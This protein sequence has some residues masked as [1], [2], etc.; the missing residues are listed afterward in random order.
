VLRFSLRLRVLLLIIAINVAVV[1]AETWVLARQL[2]QETRRETEALAEDLVF[3]LRD[4]LQPEAV[5]MEAALTEELAPLLTAW[6]PGSSTDVARAAAR[7]LAARAVARLLPRAGFNAAP[8]LS[9]PSWERFSDAILLDGNIRRTASGAIV[10]LGVALNPIGRGRRSGALD[11]QKVYEAI[12]RSIRS[13][14]PVDQIEGGRVVPI[15]GAEG[16]FGACWYQLPAQRRRDL[17]LR[18]V[19][20]AFAFSTILLSAGTFFALRRFVLDPVARLAAGAS[21]IA[22]G[23]LSV[24]VP[25]KGSADEVSRLIATFNRMTARVSGFN[26]E[27]AHE[28]ERAT[29]AARQ[30]E[31]AAMT[32]RRLAAMGE[33]AAG[34]AHEINN[35]LGGLMNAAEVLGR[36]D[37][38]VERRRRYVELL[39]GGLERIGRTVGQLLR[40]TPRSAQA[41]SLSIVQP[42]LDAVALVRHRAQA[43][44]VQLSVSDGALASTEAD[45]PA[46][47]AASLDALPRVRGEAHEIA[48]AVLNLLVNALDALEERPG[49]ARGGRVEVQLTPT[50]TGLRLEVADDGPGVAREVLERASDLF[51]TTKAPGKGTGLGLSIVHSV[52]AAHGGSVHIDSA[53]GAGFRVRIELPADGGTP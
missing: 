10:P 49:E 18:Y 19:L 1:G 52:V 33:L 53:P 37:I 38:P 9:W 27:L 32:Q 26:E 25:E 36:E 14:Q 11:E 12:A 31:A 29:A 35:P 7:D 21:A 41:V 46:P 8:L 34:I 44:G 15:R 2:G 4:K 6:L 30:A 39:A 45:L 16:V 24:R 20:P 3:T 40:F 51:F 23:D 48:Q 47:L 5:Q 50:P 22:E 42:V 13:G 43:L 17:F 28:V